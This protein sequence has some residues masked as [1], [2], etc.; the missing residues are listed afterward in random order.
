M[1]GNPE[2]KSYHGD[3]VRADYRINVRAFRSGR[4][5]PTYRSEVTIT[6]SSRGELSLS[7]TDKAVYKAL[8]RAYE[9]HEESLRF[10]EEL[11]RS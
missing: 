3:L 8:K 4:I 7:F 6:S 11:D 10:L 2:E 5:I 1:T 9:Y